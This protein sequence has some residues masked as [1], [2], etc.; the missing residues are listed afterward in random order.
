MT[1]KKF[2][3]QNATPSSTEKHF[4]IH[5]DGDLKAHSADLFKLEQ[6]LR[7]VDNAHPTLTSGAVQRVIKFDRRKGKVV[8]G[9]EINWLRDRQEDYY[10]VASDRSMETSRMGYQAHYRGYGYVWLLVE[11]TIRCLPG[12]EDRLVEALAIDINPASALD[13]LLA[14]WVNEIVE[15]SQLDMIKNLT[16]FKGVFRQEMAQRAAAIGL[17]IEARFFLKDEDSP[18]S[19]D[20]DSSGFFI[21]QPRNYADYVRLSFSARLQKDE[22]QGGAAALLHGQ[23]GRLK[24]ILM[25]G[26]KSSIRLDFDY[27]KLV[28]ELNGS[29]RDRLI[30]E[31]NNWLKVKNTGYELAEIRFE[32]DEVFEPFLLEKFHITCPL[33]DNVEIT[34][35]NTLT[36]NLENPEVFK[37]KRI[38]DLRAWASRTL[39]RIAVRELVGTSFA[40]MVTN[41][42]DYEARI[43]Q[44]FEIEAQQI[45]YVVQYFLTS[46]DVDSGTVDRIEFELDEDQW[47]FPTFTDG[48]NVKLNV[49][50]SGRIHDFQYEKLRRHLR[51]DVDLTSVIRK[52]VH[53][54]TRRFL[55]TVN[56]ND[57]YTNFERAIAGEL[58]N[59]ILSTLVEE[60]NLENDTDIILKRL[61]T[62]LIERL[63]NIQVG[64]HTCIVE[65]NDQRLKFETKFSVLGIFPPALQRFKSLNF[66]SIDAEIESIVHTLQALVQP[67]LNFFAKHLNDDHL[68]DPRLIDKVREFMKEAEVDV[69]D[70]FGL[71]IQ[72]NKGIKRLSNMDDMYF[73]EK[74][75]LVAERNIRLLN[76]QMEVRSEQY[77]NQVE[78]LRDIN[79][80]IKLEIDSTNNIERLKELQK[81]KKRI[82]EIVYKADAFGILSEKSA[83]QQNKM[84]EEF[85]DNLLGGR[86][87]SLLGAGE[88]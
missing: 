25:D 52:E 1:T 77:L 17:A 70:E 50:V 48:V 35:V 68:S 41:L 12:L 13:Q 18:G 21:V 34:L 20:I 16:G 78:E 33:R 32:T 43:K 64:V 66:P 30:E 39:T 5:Q 83:K 45:G 53:R 28:N 44:K 3:I 75:K 22:R 14:K 36:M 80:Q 24:D 73:I 15:T 67:N 31:L 2:Q 60:F 88:D 82:E 46:R 59:K 8:T 61:E 63:K 11:Y 81:E 74:K 54:T 49:I 10:L 19:I 87:Q 56:P 72:V 57:F 84:N 71:E 4:I 37:T 58:T 51:P 23:Q 79:K 85:L 38:E 26:I 6:I 62:D 86:E 69:R 65:S 42:S 40:D 47:E 76:E 9:F 27:N 55:H 7:K 29:V